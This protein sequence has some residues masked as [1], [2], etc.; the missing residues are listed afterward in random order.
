MKN[1][2]IIGIEISDSHLKIAVA[3][4][5][6]GEITVRAL[7]SV[8]LREPSDSAVSRALSEL[9]SRHKAKSGEFLCAVPRRFAILR[10]LALPSQVDS[11]I[12]KMIDLQI[13]K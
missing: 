2:Q 13:T 9:C 10:H 1:N 5:N 6:R 12:Q 11:E 7:D 4:F 3:V 8:E